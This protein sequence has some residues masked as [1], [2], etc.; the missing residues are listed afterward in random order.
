MLIRKS[1]LPQSQLHNIP[2]PLKIWN[3]N[4]TCQTF[5]QEFEP[6]LLLLVL[7]CYFLHQN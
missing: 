4:F 6:V 5:F 2:K 7:V 1:T 3:L